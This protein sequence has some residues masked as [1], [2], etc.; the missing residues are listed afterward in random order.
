[1]S[2]IVVIGSLNMDLV[3]RAGRMPAAGETIVGSEFKLIPGG[4][5]AN[6]AVAAA[7]MGGAVS[8]VGRV[9]GD[10]F[11]E[12]LRRSL[13]E[14]GVDVGRVRV[15]EDA[16]TGT[17]FIVVEEGGENRI[18]IVSG[19]NGRVGADDLREAEPL[20]AAAKAMVL[21]FE[22]RLETVEQAMRVAREHD[23]PVILNPAPAYEVSLDFLH[24]LKY[25][26]MNET[27][28]ETITGISCDESEA[29]EDAA[30]LLRRKGVETVI[31]TLGANGALVAAG[32]GIEHVPGYPV[33]ALD[34]TAAGD[35]FVGALAA[36]VA[37]G[38]PLAEAVRLANAAGAITVT[39]V[40]AQ[41]SLPTW[42][43]VAGFLEERG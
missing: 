31:I 36:S 6:Q 11:G 14:Q 32:G 16:P 24:G 1:M 2:D 13:S 42:Q 9:G 28:C 21:Q 20:I 29:V 27:E 15:D 25:L 40:G 22:V 7:R 17:A 30:D 5:G 4:K 10:P 43:E 38:K 39:R 12:T 23:V 18:I 19:A 34:T 26:V 37:R 3:V 8:M 41:P 35:A 33:E